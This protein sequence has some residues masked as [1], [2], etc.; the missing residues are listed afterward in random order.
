M[1]DESVTVGGAQFTALHCDARGI[2]YGGQLLMSTVVCSPFVLM[3]R[4][5]CTVTLTPSYG[6]SHL[7]SD[8]LSFRAA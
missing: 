2:C 5:N 8:R 6:H 4:T 3:I 1:A 7:Q